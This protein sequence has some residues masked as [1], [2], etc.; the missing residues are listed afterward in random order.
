MRTKIVN[1]VLQL[2]VLASDQGNPAQTATTVVKLEILRNFQE[3]RFEP[4][5][6]NTEI[7]ETHG[8]GVSIL[9]VRARDADTKVMHIH[10]TYSV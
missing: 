6:Y 3:P 1:I 2:R 10:Y 5:D 8:L 7:L 4:R 9:Q